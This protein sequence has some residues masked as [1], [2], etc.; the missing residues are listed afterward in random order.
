MKSPAAIHFPEY[1]A[2]RRVYHCVGIV[3]HEMS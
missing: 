2:W 3:A 1:R